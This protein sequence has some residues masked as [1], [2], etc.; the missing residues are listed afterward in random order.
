MQTWSDQYGIPGNQ[1]PNL[2]NAIKEINLN[3]QLVHKSINDNC[4][5]FMVEHRTTT[6]SVLRKIK[7]KGGQRSHL[8]WITDN[9]NH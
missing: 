1:S 4:S 2:V 7:C 6:H 5:S 3:E 9:I 8:P